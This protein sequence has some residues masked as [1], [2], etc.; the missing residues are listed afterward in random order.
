MICGHNGFE[1]ERWN[2]TWT[3]LDKQELKMSYNGFERKIKF[4]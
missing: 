1:E 3:R 4:H 2:E